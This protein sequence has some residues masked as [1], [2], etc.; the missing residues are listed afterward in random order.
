MSRSSLNISW[1][2]MADS[3]KSAVILL[4]DLMTD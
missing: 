3:R 1:Y 2:R 4:C